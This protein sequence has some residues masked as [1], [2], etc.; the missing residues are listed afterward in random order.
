VSLCLYGD[1]AA[2]LVLDEPRKAWRWGCAAAL[3][4]VALG[5][6]WSR[7][8]LAVHWVTDV[9]AGGLVAVFWIASCLWIRRLARSF[10]AK[11]LDGPRGIGDRVDEPNADPA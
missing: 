10:L 2:F 3:V 8:Y 5:I 9:V 1:L 7:L 4:L 11:R 6:C